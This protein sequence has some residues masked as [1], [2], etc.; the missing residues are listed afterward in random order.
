MKPKIAFIVPIVAHYRKTF[1]EKLISDNPEFEF[2]VFHGI[3]KKEDGRPGY[4]GLL[5]FNNETFTPKIFRIYP[6]GIVYNKGLFKGVKKFDPDIVITTGIAGD[7]SNRRIVSWTKRRKK[8]SVLWV[9]SWDS[10]K[11]KSFLKNFKNVFVKSYFRK[12][13]HFIAYGTH[14]QKYIQSF[15]I[16]KCTIDIA[17]NS[18]EISELKINEHSILNDAKHFRQ[19][20]IIN[21]D[22]F[23]FL[24]VGG[25]IRDKKIQELI[26]QFSL[27][28][29]KYPNALLWIVG[30]GPLS[31]IVQ[32]IASENNRIKY[33]GR[34]I[35]G[36]DKIFAASDCFVLPGAGGL[37]LNQAMFWKKPCI[38]GFADGTEDDL[39]IND[40][41]GFRFDR[42]NQSS[43]YNAMGKA[44]SLDLN[45]RIEFG[46]NAR[47]IIETKSNVDCMVNVFSLV[48]KN[49][50]NA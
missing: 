4:E 8:K 27:F 25:L 29:K 31:S 48:L 3:K 2:C 13:S 46:E 11:A 22:D 34:I 12:A 24:Y 28:Q 35:D 14:A 45:K 33:F 10:G 38:A 16:K 43:L 18:I 1:F 26:T 44:I 9:C 5:S 42:E 20:N 36:V 37:A 32:D 6:F 30:A 23:V 17:Y 41:T 47:E 21:D 39:V 40:F 19:K 49:Q 50:L 15:G 7:F